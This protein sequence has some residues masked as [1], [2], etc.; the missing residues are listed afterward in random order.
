M[1]REIW[2]DV[3]GYEGYYQISNLGNL[4]SVDREVQHS[5]GGTRILK[6]KT[7]RPGKTN[8]YYL[9]CLQK[10]G[11]R[12]YTTIHRLIAIAFI[13]NPENKPFINHINANGFDNRIENLE[14]CTQSEN[15]KHAY[16]M[17]AP[18]PKPMLGRTG[19][20]SSTGKEIIQMDMEGNII[21]KYG[22]GMQ[23]AKELNLS[24]AKI[25]ECARGKKIQYNGYKWKYS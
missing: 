6:G 12:K 13:P 14:W 2:K 18:S 11:K 1:K 20:D 5:R 17:G 7:I 8:W 15:I 16:K 21:K 4:K 10:H 22:S 19:Y 9:V 3:K 25:S 24:Q 23:A